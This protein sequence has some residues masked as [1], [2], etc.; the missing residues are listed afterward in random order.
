MATITEAPTPAATSQAPIPAEQLREVVHDEFEKT[1]IIDM[2]THLFMP[3]LGKLGLWGIDELLTY[4]YLEAELFRFSSVKPAQ[5]WAMNKQQQADLIWRTLFVENTPVSEACRGVIAVLSAFGLPTASKDLREAREYFQSQKL[6]AH[7]RHVFD[8]AGISE[9]VMTN[10]PLDPEEAPL[11]EQGAAPDRQFHAVL[12]LDRV[13]NKWPQHWEI[14]K[15]QGYKVEEN[16]G[17][18]TISEVR[19]FL[20]AWCARM[21]PVYMACSLPDTFQYPENSAR[22]KLLKEAVI[23][24][25]REHQIPLSVMIGVRYQVN[26]AIKLA[27]D[28]VGKADLRAVEHMCVESPDNRFLISVLSRENQHELC[29]YARKFGNLLPFG[30]WWFLNQP[31]VVEE[32]TRERI[33]ML[34]FSFIPQ[35]S[36]ARVLEQVIYKWKNTRRTIGPILAN[37]FRVL[38]EDGRTVER[39]EIRRDIHNLFRTNFERW[40]NLRGG[41]ER[42]STA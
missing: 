11:W 24:S 37:A 26:P 4:H 6:E 19:R 22:G 34:G 42:H 36:D 17:G 20:S 1:P 39:E 23:P 3:S 31:S 40:V 25:C 32:M 18:Q 35:H 7:I 21:K 8:L 13:L 33:E 9:V 10:D 2:H 30:C 15:G 14:L 27:G 12:R 5:Y 28:A 41:H 16:L 38:A 29:V